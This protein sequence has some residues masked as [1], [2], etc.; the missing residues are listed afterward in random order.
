MIHCTVFSLVS[1]QVTGLWLVII[2]G[3]TLESRQY[4]I[5]SWSGLTL[6]SIHRDI[7]LS[8]EEVIDELSKKARKL[9]F[10]L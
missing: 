4:H 9:D 3:H 1:L 5:V 7:R 8:V 2:P 10:V 6:L